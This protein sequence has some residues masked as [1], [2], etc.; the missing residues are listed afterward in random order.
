MPRIPA[1]TAKNIEISIERNILSLAQR[2]T[3]PVAVGKALNCVE[4]TCR[5]SRGNTE[6][7]IDAES[8]VEA[9]K[10]EKDVVE[11]RMFTFEAAVDGP[12]KDVLGCY[13]RSW[14]SQKNNLPVP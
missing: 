9:C 5:P 4:Q 6:K 12:M 13:S 3:P 1:T 2:L 11:E 10:N 8:K 7:D 14:L